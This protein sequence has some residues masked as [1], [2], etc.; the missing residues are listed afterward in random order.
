MYQPT[1]LPIIQS[2]RY[3]GTAASPVRL[4]GKYA[5]GKDKDGANSFLQLKHLRWNL[6]PDWFYLKSQLFLYRR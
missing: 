4:Y 6:F 2:N 3:V 1:Y 5:A